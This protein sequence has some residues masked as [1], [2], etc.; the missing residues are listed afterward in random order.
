MESIIYKAITFLPLY[1]F[2]GFDVV[3]FFYLHLF[4]IAWGH[5][6]HTN[7]NI[8]L[9]PLKY[10]FNSPQMHIWHHAKE[11]P[12]KH[13]NGVNFGLTFSIWDYLFRTAHIPSNGRD[14]ELGFEG[15]EKY[16]TGFWA[17]V[18]SGFISSKDKPQ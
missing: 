14:I 5:F 13:P 9:G 12:E 17:Q 4:T 6:N 3:D 1:L 15:D 8:P 11:L 2:F 18:L 10:L 7:I 16:P